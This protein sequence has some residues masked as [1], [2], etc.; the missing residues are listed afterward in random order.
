GP[1][2]PPRFP[3]AYKGILGVTAVDRQNR[4]LP[5]AGI[6]TPVDFA[7]PGADMKGASPDGKTVPL[8]GTSFAAPLVAARLAAHYPSPNIALIEIAVNA[9]IGE[10][11][12]LGK[13]G[14]DKVYGNG[15]IC[16]NCAVR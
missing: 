11:R 4:A 7:A 5:E 6:A 16:E 13:K 14:A 3:A 1:A 9:L 8:R 10:A 12:D 2:A 15:L